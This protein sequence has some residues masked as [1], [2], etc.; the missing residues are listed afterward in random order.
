[1][2]QVVRL[3]PRHTRVKSG[4]SHSVKSGHWKN[5]FEEVSCEMTRRSSDSLL[6]PS[7]V[8]STV[9]TR[10]LVPSPVA[11]LGQATLMPRWR[12]RR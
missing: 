2:V 12:F 3:F 5:W 6:H 1:M 7:F 11:Q 8:T 10:T 4:S 9:S